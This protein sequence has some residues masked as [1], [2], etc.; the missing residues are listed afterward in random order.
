MKILL[1]TF[2][3]GLLNLLQAQNVQSLIDQG[4]YLQA[5]EEAL[6][7]ADTENLALASRAATF[8]ADYQ[9]PSEDKNKWYTKAEEAAQEALKLDNKNA[10]AYSYLAQAQGR[11]GQYR[12]I[13]ESLGLA[14]A[15]KNNAEKALE[16]DP[17]LNEAK[18][19]LAIWHSELTARGVGWLYGASESKALEL[20]QSVSQQE[21]DTILYQFEYANILQRLGKPD[22]ARSYYQNVLDLSPQVSVDT[23][24][25]EQAKQAL[26]ILEG[27]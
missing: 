26:E 3:L 13:L 11:L 17:D 14:D 2:F 12:G 16:L 22:E 1:V 10:V 6:G 25:L 9:A 18:I 15:I 23:Y 27:N 5:Y 7:L 21:A 4:N 19:T 8:Y 24:M 20:M